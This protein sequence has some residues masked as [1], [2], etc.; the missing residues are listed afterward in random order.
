MNRAAKGVYGKIIG[1]TERTTPIV[2][3][4]YMS[5]ARDLVSTGTPDQV[6][7]ILMFCP[8]GTPLIAYLSGMR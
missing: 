3:H 5:S 6:K 8:P 1:L 4:S 7:G 2:V